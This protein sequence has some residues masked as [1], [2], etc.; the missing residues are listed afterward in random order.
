MEITTLGVIVPIIVGLITILG[1]LTGAFKWLWLKIVHLFKGSEELALRIPKKTLVMVPVPGHGAYWW[2]MGSLAE[3]PAMQIVGHYTITNV[4]KLGIVPTVAKLKKPRSL[5]HVM[6]REITSQ[7]HGSF[8]IPPSATT[9]LQFDFWIV[10]P[11]RKEGEPFV[12][13]VAVLDQ[14]GNEH[15]LRRIEFVYR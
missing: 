2:H 1:T 13:D 14:F 11:V 3:K 5:G 8:V 9:D 10:P 4:T 12:A 15:W 6:V 7:M